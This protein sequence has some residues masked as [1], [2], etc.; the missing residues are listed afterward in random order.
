[1]RSRLICSLSSAAF[2]LALALA[3]DARAD[4]TRIRVAVD[5]LPRADEGAK[6]EPKDAV[7]PNGMRDHGPVPKAWRTHDDPS[8]FIESSRCTDD[9]RGSIGTMYGTTASTQKIWEANGKAFFDDVDVETVWGYVEVKR[10]IRVPLARIT[11][12]LW[13]YRRKDSVV[14]VA[15]RDT[16]FEDGGFYQC[17]IDET[18]LSVSGGSTVLVSSPKDVNDA[19]DRIAKNQVEPGKKP[20]PHPPW[21]GVELRVLASVAKSSSDASAI[22][23]VVM[24]KP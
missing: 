9:R 17:R 12:G 22:L 16:G 8:D 11:D 19:M 10:A 5:E 15:A 23:N 2:A 21:M 7:L 18:E 14:L 24:K 13:A 20:K 6:I 3:G 1:M 4:V